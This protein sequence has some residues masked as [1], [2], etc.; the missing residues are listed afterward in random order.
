MAFIAKHLHDTNSKFICVI[1]RGED[2]KYEVY[3]GEV[4]DIDELAAAAEALAQCLNDFQK[5]GVI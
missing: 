2:G 3:N 5:G 4:V 1:G